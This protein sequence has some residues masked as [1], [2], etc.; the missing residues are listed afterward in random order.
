MLDTKYYLI[1]LFDHEVYFYFT[2]LLTKLL[3]MA[4]SNQTKNTDFL[5]LS[6]DVSQSSA[7]YSRSS[8]LPCSAFVQKSMLSAIISSLMTP[9][10]RSL[11][12]WHILICDFLPAERLCLGLALKLGF[13]HYCSISMGWDGSG[14]LL[15]AFKS[16]SDRTLRIMTPIGSIFELLTS[17]GVLTWWDVNSM[18]I[19]IRRRRIFH[20]GKVLWR[21]CDVSTANLDNSVL[22][23]T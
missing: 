2:E 15:A 6:S 1:Q 12:L 3:H 7:E 21:P 14:A 8:F 11:S 9:G 4:L 22:H 20:E 13:S 5:L 19:L 17:L 23:M 18:P 16:T 10:S